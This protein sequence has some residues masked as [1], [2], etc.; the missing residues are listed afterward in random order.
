MDG[1]QHAVAVREQLPPERVGET[2]ELLVH[3]L[4]CHD[5]ASRDLHAAS[6]TAI[7]TVG[8]DNRPAL[9]SQHAPAGGERRSLGVLGAGDTAVRGTAARTGAIP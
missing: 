7:L 4:L 2:G 9:T 3:L 8:S 1:S 5:C 6:D